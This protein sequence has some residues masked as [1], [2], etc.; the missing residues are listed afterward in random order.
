MKWLRRRKPNRRNEPSDAVP[1]R[2]PRRIAFGASVLVMAAAAG[3]FGVYLGN[4][5]QEKFKALEVSGELERV[6][7]EEVRDVL[8]P[9]VAQGFAG[10]DLRVARESLEALPWIAQASVRREWP[11]TLLVD[12]VEE[13]PIATWFGTALMNANGQVFVDGAAGYSGVLP[14]VGGPRGSQPDMVGRLQELRHETGARGLELRRLLRTDRR[15]ERFWLANGIEVRLGRR[16]VEARLDRFLDVAWPRLAARASEIAY[17]DMRY[18]NGFAVG[19]KA[20]GKP[21]QGK[22]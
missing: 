5:E 4:L 9:Y 20:V 17:V 14:D 13:E 15:A 6:S 21:G 22:G 3:A 8:A 12:V 19:W 10:I 18:T 1:S 11:G 16:D 7:A 2:W